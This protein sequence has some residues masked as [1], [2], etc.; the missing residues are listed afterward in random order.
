M[1]ARIS[2]ILFGIVLMAFTSCEYDNFEEPTSEFSGNITYNGEA[3]G[4]DSEDISFELWEQPARKAPAAIDVFVSQ[5]GSFSALLFDASY[6]MVFK[7]STYPFVVSPSSAELGDTMMVQVAGNTTMDIE[8]T[9]YYLI[10]D[11]Q[12]KANGRSID[13]TFKI[14]QVVK[15][16]NA[17]DIDE[18]RL[19]VG[20]THFVGDR[21]DHENERLKDVKPG[22]TV[23][24]NVAVDDGGLIYNQDKFYVR[25][26][27]EVKGISEQLY[28]PVVEIELPPVTE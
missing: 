15:G 23:T 16:D 13:A 20:T 28:S 5:E 26:G 6:K 24:I 27:L 2:Y 14:E 7:S 1:K 8:V 11:V 3:L 12:Y 21:I 18:V 25:I 10:K 17:K 22:E 19:Y 9:P 4:F